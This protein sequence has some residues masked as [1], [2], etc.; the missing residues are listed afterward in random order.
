MR[1]QIVTKGIVLARTDFQEADRI[2]TV[3]TPD[4]GRLRLM[5]KG[6]RRPKSKLA[7]GIEL[8][9]INDLT[10]LPGKSEIQTLISS[11]M[12]KNFGNIVKDIQKTMLGYDLIKRLN[13]YMED[14][15]GPEYY[16]MLAGVLEG[17]N[18]SDLTQ[19]LVDLWF[20]VQLLKITGHIPN[21]MSDTEGKQLEAK[22]SYLFDFEASAFRQQAGGPYTSQHIKLLRLAYSVETPTV[23]KQVKDVDAYLKD[24]LNLSRNILK[25]YISN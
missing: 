22:E 5:A 7:G 3:L 24:A 13:K 9:T 15:P 16:Q 4:H 11:R 19:D 6:V 25:Q 17:L 12:D 23:L 2:L 20:N 21:L 8:F 1:S 10:I 14:E 18:E